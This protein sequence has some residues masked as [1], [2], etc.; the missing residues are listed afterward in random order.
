LTITLGR[1]DGGVFALSG[2]ILSSYAPKGSAATGINMVAIFNEF[3]ER[4]MGG[5]AW[6][7]VAGIKPLGFMSSRWYTGTSR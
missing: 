5:A 6:F 1:E 4:Q 2:V 7:E 3:F